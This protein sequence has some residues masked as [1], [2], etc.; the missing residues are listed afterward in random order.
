MRANPS[1]D[2]PSTPTPS[3]MAV[4]SSRSVIATLFSCPRMSTN[5]RW[6]ISTSRSSQNFTTS[7]AV[8]NPSIP[9]PPFPRGGR[10]GTAPG[11]TASTSEHHRR[12][13]L[14]LKAQL[15]VEAVL[16]DREQEEVGHRFQI[17]MFEHE[18]HHRR[19]DSVSLVRGPHD[20]VPDR[21]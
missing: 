20:H 18:P 3:S 17:G 16:V 19:A 14:G 13:P 2:E 12:L 1:T 4:A 7:F 5:Q 10:R 9:S 8:F 6:I 11:S 15:L 21:R